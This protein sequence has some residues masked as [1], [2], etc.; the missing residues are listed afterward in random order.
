MFIPAV[1]GLRLWHTLRAVADAPP[2]DHRTSPQ[3]GLALNAAE[4]AGLRYLVFRDRACAAPGG[5]RCH[6]RLFELP[7]DR[8]RITVGRTA[9]TDLSLE[10]DPDVSRAHCTLERVGAYWTVIDDGLSR[11]GTF[12]NGRRVLGTESLHGGDRL[13]LGN[14]TLIYHAPRD[15]D[16]STWFPPHPSVVVTEAERRVLVELCRPFG[17]GTPYAT[18]P[19]NQ[20]IASALV[21]TVETVKAHL[22][23]LFDKLEIED[24]PQQR[25]RVRLAQRTLETGVIS[26]YE[27]RNPPSV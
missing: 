3:E 18:A 22:R 13:Q 16:V 20:E 25:K 9:A 14:T 24:L 11:N 21:V 15:V 6:Q 1:G 8:D 5:G 26:R 10:F 2:C 23:T 4:R 27:L 7:D 17:D 19:S 12:I